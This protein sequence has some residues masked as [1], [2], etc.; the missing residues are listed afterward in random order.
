MITQLMK[1]T[2][3]EARG[4]KGKAWDALRIGFGLGSSAVN[5]VLYFDIRFT[6]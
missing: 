2:R 6:F 4:I 3:T 5:L 1:D